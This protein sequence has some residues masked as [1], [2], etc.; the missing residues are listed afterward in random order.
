MNVTFLKLLKDAGPGVMI[1]LDGGVKLNGVAAISQGSGNE[2]HQNAVILL[3][4][5]LPIIK[6]DG[7]YRGVFNYTTIYNI[8]QLLPDNEASAFR[9]VIMERQFGGNWLIGIKRLAFNF[10]Y[11]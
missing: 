6:N 2:I 5:G 11:L 4:M 7:L 1:N 8:C 10:G 9:A 3:K